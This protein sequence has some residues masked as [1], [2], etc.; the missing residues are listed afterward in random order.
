MADRQGKKTA[1]VQADAAGALA[2]RGAF[3]ELAD[4]AAAFQSPDQIF[5]CRMA[6][7]S[8]NVW[9]LPCAVL[10]DGFEINYEWDG[11]IRS[12][13]DFNDRS[14]SNALLILKDGRIVTEVYRNGSRPDT[15]FISFSMAKSITST[16]VGM[17]VD[18]GLIDDVSDPLTKYLPSL[19]GSAYDGVAIRDALQMVSGVAWDEADYDWADASKPLTRDWQLSL[20]EHRFRFVEG[21][22]RLPRSYRPGEHYNYSTLESCILGW[23]IET[24]TQQRMTH[25]FE[26]RLWRPMRAEF[27]ASWIIDG[28]EDIGREMAGAALAATLRDYGRFGQMILAGG[29]ADGR[30]L[31]SSD[32]LDA[33]TTADRE[34]IQYGNIDEDNS[35]GYGYQWWLIED[36]RFE[37]Q[38]IY[39][40]FIHVVPHENVVIVKLSYWA[41]PWVDS[42]ET[43]CRAFF[44]AV[45]EATRSLDAAGRAT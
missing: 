40:Q 38:G 14:N 44:N 3:F 43:E 42:I 16:L 8:D 17:T 2:R 21:A 5:P 35:I 34:A 25:Y 9:E 31:V 20:V 18:D 1:G 19:I 10:P 7:A 29:E 12:V 39:G 27:D 33:A 45:I 13:E 4:R 24:V 23:L 30:R 37:A 26:Q 28:P 15:R 11:E 22:N 32:W 41:D 6:A 36:G